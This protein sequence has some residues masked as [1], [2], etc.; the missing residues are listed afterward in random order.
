MKES[1]AARSR[2]MKV[3]RSRNAPHRSAVYRT[4]CLKPLSRVSQACL[5][6]SINLDY[7]ATSF[8]ATR[9]NPNKFIA[10]DYFFL[11]SRNAMFIIQQAWLQQ[12]A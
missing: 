10:F 6:C 2:P 5:N 9:C 4:S 1:S 7:I 11:L 8:L 3:T 12:F